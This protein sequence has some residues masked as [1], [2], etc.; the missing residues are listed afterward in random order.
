M[1]NT[2]V[3]HVPQA[4]N[5][6]IR[7]PLLGASV[8]LLIAPAALA[9]DHAPLSLPAPFTLDSLGSSDLTLS[10]LQPGGGAPDQTDNLSN[11]EENAERLRS[12]EL[13]PITVVG[14]APVGLREEDRIGPYG[15][16]RWTATRRFPTTRV[17][18]VPEGKVEV[19]AWARG[20]FDDGEAKWRFLQEIEIGLPHRFQL[21]LYVRQDYETVSDEVEWGGQFE[22]RYA[23]A[24]WGEIWGN[25]T[26]YF[27]YVALDNRPDKIEPK[28]LLGGEVTERWH[29]GANFVAELE[30]GGAREY[31]YQFTTGLSYSVVDSVFSIGVENIFLFADDETN[32]GDF[33][34]SFVIGPSIQWRPVPAMTVNIAPLIGV[35]P[36]SP[37]AQVWFNAGWEF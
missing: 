32:R 31:E 28:V 18:V 35:G 27:E 19:E 24:D 3:R 21:D 33:T 30:L 8:A 12:W 5:F 22:V 7:R 23:L 17:Y 16:P 14:D 13:P 15:Q 25:P 34:T 6:A 29:W 11:E 9:V 10:A 36:D 20:T 4:S 1:L 37:D 2:L 26:L